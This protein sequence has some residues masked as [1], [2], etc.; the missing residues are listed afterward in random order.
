MDFVGNVTTFLGG[1]KLATSVALVLIAILIG[2]TDLAAQEIYTTPS[3]FAEPAPGVTYYQFP[4]DFIGNWD[5]RPDERDCGSLTNERGDPR[6]TCQYPVSR[7]E[8]IMNDRARAWIEFFDEPISPKWACV[9]GNVTTELGDIYM[10]NL[11]LNE[12]AVIQHFEQSNW[13]RNIWV[14]GRGHPPTTQVFYQGHSIGKMEGDVFVVETTNFAFD[15]DGMD[16]Q[17][18]I[19]TSHLKKQWERYSV[20]DSN[21]LKLEITIEDPIFFNE[22]FTWTITAVRDDTAFT[23]EWSC[24]TGVG[25][26]HLYSTIDQRYP[27]DKMFEL[28]DSRFEPRE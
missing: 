9:S 7:L 3:P 10:W 22:P 15:P 20:I 23:G 6:G 24:D 14:D 4:R 1:R 17:S 16:D 11:S 19:A 8:E 26:R 25:L 28:Y 27:G 12:D 13:R 21:T 18:H 5:P 2:Q